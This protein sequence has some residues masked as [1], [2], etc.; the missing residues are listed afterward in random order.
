MN[1]R[2]ERADE[3]LLD[4]VDV[5]VVGGGVVGCAVL[6]ELSGFDIRVAMVEARHDIGDA[7]S[8]ANTAILHT[9][10]DAVPGS[11]ESTLVARG[12][13]LLSDY[14]S[15]TG[16]PVESTGALLVAWDEEQLAALPSL[17]AKAEKN[18]YRDCV[19]VDATTVYDRVPHLGPGALGGLAVP[20]ESIIC[21]WTTPLAYATE[22]LARGA[23]V[24]LA[25]AVESVEVGPE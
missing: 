13:A 12:Y 2:A 5:L 8:K 24:H 7:T 21:P 14:A 16:I 18:G 4:D 10:F 11:Q 20:G 22:A 23:H 6:R 3:D 19:L 9:G 15:R 1:G 17:L 25:A